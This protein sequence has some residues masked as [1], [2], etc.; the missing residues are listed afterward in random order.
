MW[1]ESAILACSLRDGPQTNKTP[2][3][4]DGNIIKGGNEELPVSW[5]VTVFTITLLQI[6]ANRLIRPNLTTNFPL[7]RKALA[8]NSFTRPYVARRIGIGA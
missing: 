3:L 1:C 4:H 2:G 6:F 8:L 7:K 5:G